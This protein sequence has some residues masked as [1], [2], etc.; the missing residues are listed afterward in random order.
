MNFKFFIIFLLLIPIFVLAL[1]PSNDVR[2]CWAIEKGETIEISC[3]YLDK[4]QC[5]TILN[6][7]EKTAIIFSLQSNPLIKYILIIGLILLILIIIWVI[8]KR[9]MSL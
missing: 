4:F 7:W 6:K 9:K 5:E 2:C 8:K 1:D 3:E